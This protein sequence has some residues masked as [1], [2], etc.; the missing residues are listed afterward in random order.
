MLSLCFPRGFNLQVFSVFLWC[1]DTERKFQSSCFL[2]VFFGCLDLLLALHRGHI[3]AL[4]WICW[5]HDKQAFMGGGCCCRKCL[6][7]EGPRLL[8]SCCAAAAAAA[9]C[10]ATGGGGGSWGSAFHLW[11]TRSSNLKITICC[12]H[13]VSFEWQEQYTMRV[14]LSNTYLLTTL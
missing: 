1:L 9:N 2:F 3:G 13:K 11:G 8:T 14:M 10:E 6:S 12:Y 5:W 4:R 7:F